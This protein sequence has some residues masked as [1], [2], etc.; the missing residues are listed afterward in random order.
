MNTYA[1]ITLILASVGLLGVGAWLWQLTSNRSLMV[2]TMFGCL[3]ML[4]AAYH[5]VARVQTE[6]AIILPFFATM[7][8]GGRA[9]GTWWRSRQEPELARPAQALWA[10]TVLGLVATGGAWLWT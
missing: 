3:G 8:Y 6:W 5:A 9:F 1:G 7:L 10:A 2:Y 4:C